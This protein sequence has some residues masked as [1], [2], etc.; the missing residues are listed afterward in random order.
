MYEETNKE[1]RHKQKIN[2]IVCVLVAIIYTIITLLT[3]I[4]PCITLSNR[5]DTFNRI[6][7]SSFYSILGVCFFIV[8]VSMNVS[9]KRY[10]K[11]FYNMFCC[12]LW[13]ACFCLTIP[14]VSFQ[15]MCVLF[16]QNVQIYNVF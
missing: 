15:M 7:I 8:G 11:H 1:L 12:F 9:L 5:F 4:D 13:T 16:K 3:T 14:D 6:T 2:N 10:F